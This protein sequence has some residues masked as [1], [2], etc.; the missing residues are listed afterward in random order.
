[1]SLRRTMKRTK[2]S[3]ALCRKVFFKKI[4]QSKKYLIAKR[5]RVALV[6][7][8]M[9]IPK[10]TSL[11]RKREIPVSF[12]YSKLFLKSFS[13]LLVALLWGGILGVN[14][15]SSYYN[16]N[17]E[18]LGDSFVAGV[19]DFIL[20]NGDF[21]PKE[22][23]LNFQP[24]TTTSK[25]VGVALEPG[26]NPMRYHARTT[27]IIGD[28]DFC[29]AIDLKASRGTSTEF[30]GR[31]VDFISAP[32]TTIGDWQYDFSYG[33]STASYNSICS[34][35][36]EYSGR[37]TAPHHEYDDGGYYDTETVPNTLYSWGFHINKVYYAVDA[38]HGVEGN[39]EWV[40]IYNQT[41]SA[42]DI[43]GWQICDDMS[44]DTIPA[45]TTPIMVPAKGFAVITAASTTWKYWDVP[46][47]VVKIE[48]D[49][50]IGDGLS[51]NGDKL[52]LKR[53]DGR[54]MDEMNWGTNTDVWNPGAPDVPEGHMLGRKANGYDT[55]Q[56]SDFVNLAIPSVLLINPNQSGSQTW[57]WTYLY[58]ITWNATNPNGPDGDIAINLSYIKDSDYSGTITPG[59]ETVVIATDL[60]N[61]GSYSWHLP[62]GFVGYIWVKIVAVGPE[63]PMLHARM[64]S[65]K[66]WDPF[67]LKTP[68]STD[69]GVAIESIV[70]ILAAND[71]VAA[72][73]GE[74][75]IAEVVD[76]VTDD[77]ATVV[78]ENSGGVSNSVDEVVKPVSSES[79]VEPV[80]EPGDGAVLDVASEAGTEVP[81][82]ED[83]S[84]AA[85]IGT[86][87]VSDTAVRP[88][89]TLVP[90]HTSPPTPV[91]EELVPIPETEP[92]LVEESIHAPASEPTPASGSMLAS[93]SESVTP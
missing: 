89:P 26:S 60:T 75:E 68:V 14:A 87:S 10:C 33:S 86:V 61:S 50:N 8:A 4:K 90:E 88:E 28:T 77:T 48:L 52:T 53:P 25:T 71:F 42:L 73:T 67:S 80:V 22:G 85:T 79:V 29:H 41:D 21:T 32:T 9:G 84:M 20:I 24:G 39:N 36:L 34:F 2:K 51:N 62:G 37:Q 35:D 76:E 83:A 46:S 1:M 44:C 54:V 31:L 74:K 16:D 6:F 64:I 72:P 43:G 5:K 11:G 13:V 19:L 45:S 38:T 18:S 78:E 3:I 23:A 65:G 59:D 12:E 17:E 40:E 82:V 56:P 7:F 58:N 55:N 91:L 27:N 92:V 93:V 63:N 47:D 30:N 49:N 66:V 81:E 57:Y 15:T 70:E 69:S